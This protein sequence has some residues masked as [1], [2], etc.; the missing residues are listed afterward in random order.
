MLPFPTS[1]QE[2]PPDLVVVG[3][4]YNMPVERS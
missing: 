1:K 2:M 4:S 3:L